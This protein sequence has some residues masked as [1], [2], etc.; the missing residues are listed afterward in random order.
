MEAAPGSAS[1]SPLPPLGPTLQTRTYLRVFLASSCLEKWIQKLCSEPRLWRE[2][3][4][5]AGSPDS[6]ALD[7]RGCRREGGW[8]H[9]TKAGGSPRG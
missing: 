6:R 8:A 1:S 9:G 7:T 2:G 4:G 5:E 3:C